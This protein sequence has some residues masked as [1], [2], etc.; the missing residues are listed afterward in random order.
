MSPQHPLQGTKV[1]EANPDNVFRAIVYNVLPAN[2]DEE[3]RMCLHSGLAFEQVKEK[4]T[5]VRDRLQGVCIY[6]RLINVLVSFGT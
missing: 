2:E 6:V 4:E 5:T 3:G 1:E